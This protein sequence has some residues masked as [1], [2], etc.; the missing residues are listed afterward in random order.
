MSNEKD[1]PSFEE[2]GKVLRELLAPVWRSACSD[3]T[4]PTVE[5]VE[6]LKQFLAARHQE[7]ILRDSGEQSRL[8]S[9]LKSEDME[10][11]L[12]G[13]LSEIQMTSPEISNWLKNANI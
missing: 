3:A 5:R 10:N 6:R 11:R 12:I 9:E 1:E 4:H 13:L 2:L 7:E 8:A